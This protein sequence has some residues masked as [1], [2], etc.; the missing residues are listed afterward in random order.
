MIYGLT[1]FFGSIRILEIAV[2]KNNTSMPDAQSERNHN[3]IHHG[4]FY[5]RINWL[6][7][8]NSPLAS[9]R[10]YP[11]WINIFQFCIKFPRR[12]SLIENYPMPQNIKP[13]P[14]YSW[15]IS[16]KAAH[17]TRMVS[18]SIAISEVRPAQGI[19]MKN[20]IKKHTYI[21]AH[22]Y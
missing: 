2:I 13:I 8:D 10:L 21:H 19:Y 11:A 15:M 22:S 16:G 12:R 7:V 18:S 1:I 14:N 20:K 4:I 17:S 3:R 6:E 5:V 9:G